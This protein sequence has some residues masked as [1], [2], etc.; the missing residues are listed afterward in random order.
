MRFLGDYLRGDVYYKTSRPGQNL[1]RAR[2][3]IKMVQEMEQKR[4]EMEAI[5][6]RC[7]P[8]GHLL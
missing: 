6:S 8:P 5:L 1:D 3:Q 7:K 4:E 2:N